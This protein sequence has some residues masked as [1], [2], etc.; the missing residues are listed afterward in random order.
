V[1]AIGIETLISYA[2]RFAILIPAIVFHEVA[3]GYAAL[4]LG[5]ETAKSEKRLS[6]NPVRH[7]DP[8]GTLLMPALLLLISG[9]SFAFGYA[10]PVP[11]NPMRFRADVD[12]RWGMLLVGLAGPATN[13]ALA[14]VSAVVFRLLVIVAPASEVWVVVLSLLQ[15]FVYLNLLLMIFNLVPIPPL[16]GSRVL[17]VILPPAARPA[18]YNL[19]R[20]GFPILFVILFLVPMVFGFSPLGWLLSVTAVPLTQLFTGIPLG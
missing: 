4:A 19:E 17:P 16:D 9:G 8:W 6:L 18:V 1:P 10:K 12:R 15:S 7:I 11:V 20:Y 13:L 3:H 14:A 5:D 2:L